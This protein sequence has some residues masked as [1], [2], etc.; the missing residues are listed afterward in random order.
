VV[1]QGVE[2]A[3]PVEAVKARV[4][5]EASADAVVQADAVGGVGAVRALVQADEGVPADAVVQ[6]AEPEAVAEPNV[7]T[8][9]VVGARVAA[10]EVWRVAAQVAKARGRGMSPC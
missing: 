1:V 4:A 3:A 10:G 6:V 8:Q 2:E 5:R 7:K 9:Q